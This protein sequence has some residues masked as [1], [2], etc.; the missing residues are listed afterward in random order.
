MSSAAENAILVA[1][2]ED[3]KFNSSDYILFYAKGADSWLFNKLDNLFHH[4]K[5]LYSDYSYYF[6]TYN[7]G[8]GKRIPTE[9]STNDPVTDVIETFND[10]A[11]YEKNDLSLIKSGREWFDDEIYDATTTRNFAFSFP[12]L[13]TEKPV[14]LKADLAARS[15]LGTTSF[16]L[17]ISS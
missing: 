15:T 3:G 9:P 5:N 6:L 2:E 7:Q 10:F 12:N 1:R 11:F 4:A 17:L 8:P 16:S 14:Y 13:V